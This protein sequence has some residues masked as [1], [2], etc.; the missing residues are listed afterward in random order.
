[1]DK[2][3]EIL[4][5]EIFDWYP[6]KYPSKSFI[7]S[8]M[9][10]VD[11]NSIIA[12]AGLFAPEFVE[13]QGHIFLLDNVKVRI[14]KDEV[15]SSPYGKDK[16]TIERYNNLFHL[17]E[18]FIVTASEASRD[19]RMLNKFGKLLIF[20]WSRRLKEIFPDKS[21]N[22]EIEYDLYDEDGLCLTFWQE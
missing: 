11:I 21:F 20:F 18:F 9:N 4:N 22:F 2:I 14:E 16:A 1:M 3:K 8:A 7:D 10:L 5:E 17:G 13:L 15:F 19:I 6:N 12:V